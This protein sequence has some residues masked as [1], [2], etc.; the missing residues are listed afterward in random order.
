MTPLSDDT[1]ASTRP[2]GVAR[3]L[4]QR[5]PD[6]QPQRRGGLLRLARRSVLRVLRPYTSYQRTVD[7]KLLDAIDDL[8]RRVREQERMQLETL[9]EDLLDALQKLSARLAEAEETVTA[10]RAVPYSAPGALEQFQQPSAGVVLGYR[11]GGV[12]SQAKYLD[13]E[14][15]FRG[16]EE[17]VRERQQVYL[18]LVEPHQPVLDAGCGRGE[19]L[20]LMRERGISYLGV[21]ADEAM[22]ER[23]RAKGHDGVQ[24]ADVNEYLEHSGEELGAVFSAQ[25]VEHLGHQELLRFLRLSHARLRPGGIFVAE[26]VNPHAPHALKTFWVDPTHRHPLFP[27]VL[28]VLCRLAG[29]ASAYVFHPLGSGHVDDDRF[30]E[31]EYALVAVKQ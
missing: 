20:D 25:L 30:R 3:E 17:R 12:E 21:D 29:F 10:S 15:V 22:A 27:E 7:G 23:C 11:D 9:T 31:S 24:V 1:A 6:S 19:F 16:P 5:G 4:T 2:A 14:Q 26:T 28:L 18:D 13:F 8:D